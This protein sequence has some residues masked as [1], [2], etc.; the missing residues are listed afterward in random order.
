MDSRTQ[1]KKQAG[2]F[3]AGFVESGMV[4]GLGTGSTAI[5]AVRKIG[6]RIRTGE[7]RNII[8]IATS[9]QT[10]KEAVQL[11]IP[12]MQDTLPRDVDITIDGADEVDPEWNVIKGGGGALL[13]EKIVAQVSRRFAIVVDEDK[14][15]DCLGTRFYLPIE[16]LRFGWESQ[17]RFVESLGARVEIRKNSDGTDYATD[18]GNMIFQAYFGPMQDPAALSAKLGARAGIIEHGL[19]AGLATDLVVAGAKGVQHQ[20]K[21]RR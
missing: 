13:R 12:L 8:G 9:I 17:K 20:H 11:G 5:H 4:V 2:E 16:V 6:E 7:L 21:E 14:I 3:A 1:L 19:F 15:S 10:H 18:S